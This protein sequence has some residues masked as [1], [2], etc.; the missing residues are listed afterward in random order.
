MMEED[1]QSN[2]FLDGVLAGADSMHAGVCGEAQRDHG[3][4]DVLRE[5]FI[6]LVMKET[7]SL[8]G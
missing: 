7:V 8:R 5:A 6:E 3:P 2:T 1:Q 4:I